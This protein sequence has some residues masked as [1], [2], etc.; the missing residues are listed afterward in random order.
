MRPYQKNKSKGTG[1]MAQVVEH[2][3]P[4]FKA[5]YHQKAKEGRKEKRKRKKPEK[6]GLGQ[7]QIKIK[8]N[9]NL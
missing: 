8:K 2:L 1:G 6:A 3:K 5:Q 7:N 9:K 4:E